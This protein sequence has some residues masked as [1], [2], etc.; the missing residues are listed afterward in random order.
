MHMVVRTN[1]E[2]HQLAVAVQRT[3]FAVDPAA[4]NVPKIV[5]SPPETDDNETQVAEKPKPRSRYRG[6]S[7][8]ES[9]EERLLDVGV[10]RERPD[11]NGS[12]QLDLD[13]RYQPRP[14]E[15]PPHAAAPSTS[16]HA[17]RTQP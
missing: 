9:S 5:F 6:Q 13:P 17:R 8:D 14:E 12:W 2:P 3:V 7:P 4:G 1:V 11:A 10:C 16:T 15:Q